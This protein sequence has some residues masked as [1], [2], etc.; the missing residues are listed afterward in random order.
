MSGQG[1]PPCRLFRALQQALARWWF[2][3]AAPAIF[4]SQRPLVAA[5]P[6]DVRIRIAWGGGEAR[7]W[8]GT[9]QLSEGTLSDIQPLGLEA[10]EPGSML[11]IDDKSLHVFPRTPRSYDG[12]DLRVQ[13]PQEAKLLVQLDADAN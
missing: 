1:R 13:A 2:V 8:R 6:I 12:L 5:E 11:L 4:F 9:I 7:A 3:L 10:D